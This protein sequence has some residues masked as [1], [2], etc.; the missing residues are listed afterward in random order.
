MSYNDFLCG[1]LVLTIVVTR[2][3]SMLHLSA[4]IYHFGPVAGALTSLLDH[5][6]NQAYLKWLTLVEA[7][8]TLV[9]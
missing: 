2:T 7:T 6:L 5:R 9:E 3:Y 1:L 4:A 8:A